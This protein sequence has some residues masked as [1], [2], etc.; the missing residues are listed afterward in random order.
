MRNTHTL[1]LKAS[2]ENVPEAIECVTQSALAAGFDE[3]AVL[4]IQVA[5]DEACANVVQH[6]YA[7]TR[8]GD[9]E[10]TCSLDGHSFVVRVRNWGKRFNPEAVEEPD[11][12]APLEERGLGGLGLFLIQQF[13]DQAQYTFDP[14]HGNE[15][16]MVKRLLVAEQ[17]G[18][19]GK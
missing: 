7:G 17:N 1:R 3:Q 14:K 13:M 6:A 19:G 16:I 15:L 11:V 4:Q 12:A 2:L 5:V 10:V 18:Q 8:D 9:M